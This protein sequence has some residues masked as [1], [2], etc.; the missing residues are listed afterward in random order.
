ME[1][2]VLWGLLKKRDFFDRVFPFLKDHHFKEDE[3]VL[4]FKLIKQHHSKFSKFPSIEEIEVDSRLLKV[5]EE[6]LNQILKRLE[7]LKRK[8]DYDSEWL[9]EKAEQFCKD[10]ELHHALEIAIQVVTGENKSLRREALSTLIGEAVS[11]SF[12]DSVGHDYFLDAEKRWEEEHKEEN[13]IPFHLSMLNKVTDGGLPGGT[14]TVPLAAVNTGKSLFLCDYAANAMRKGFNVGYITLE[15]KEKIVAQR[16]DANLNRVSVNSVL[17]SPKEIYL[18]N[19]EEIRGRIKG[20]LNIKE[21]PTKGATV[22]DIKKFF[23]DV[24]VKRGYQ[25]DVILVDYLNLL[26]SHILIRNR[27]GMYEYVKSVAEELRKLAGELNVPVIAPTQLNRNGMRSSAPEMEDVSE[28][29]GINETADF[30]FT[31]VRTGELR[32]LGK[33]QI[34]QIKNRLGNVDHFK[35]FDVFISPELMSLSENELMTNMN[36]EILSEESKEFEGFII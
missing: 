30:I 16:V 29:N 2:L 17:K 27:S 14:L 19:I 6:V 9:I 22:L 18:S 12:D 15:L 21:F 20:N 24:K 1:D 35:Q 25:L 4:I 10:A 32:D 26:N 11:F 5:K 3:N 34:R 7:S 8:K 31:M 36:S 28:S 23:H 13:R 33:V